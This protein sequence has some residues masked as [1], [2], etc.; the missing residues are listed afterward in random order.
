MIFALDLEGCLAPEIW[1]ALGA[2]FSVREF[3]LTTRDLG[4][5][6]ELMRL[7][8]AAARAA[9]LR[10]ADLQVIAHAVEPYLGAREFVA[11]LRALGNVII[12]SDTFHEFADPI[13]AR[14]GGV[15]LF[16]NQF[17][18]DEAGELAG[19]KLRIRGQKE[20]LVTGFKSAGFKVAAMGDSMNDYSL[21]G[22][23]DY[24]LMFRPVEAL[25]AKFPG[26]P[27]AQNLDE[28]LA[29]FTDARR[30]LDESEKQG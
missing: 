22:S 16:A 13:A 5:F 25:R 9:G 3:S 6:D 21:L 2:Q 8:V 14:L 4:D 28:A 26:A 12:I 18:V 27:E 10:L 29:F 11:R 17:E 24:P 30:R 15:N 19:I 20:R 7:R 1:P 23:C